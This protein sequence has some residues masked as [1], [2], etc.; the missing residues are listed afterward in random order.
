MLSSLDGTSGNI[1]NFQ[2]FG[3]N[4]VKPALANNGST[5]FLLASGTESSSGGESPAISLAGSYRYLYVTTSTGSGDDDFL[6]RS[7]TGGSVPVP[8]SSVPEPASL[9]LLAAG[10]IGLAGAGAAGEDASVYADTHASSLGYGSPRAFER[11]QAQR[12]SAA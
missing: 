5:V 4:L 2:I 11:Q 10:L 6:L 3:S 9:A 7:A 12:R 1:D 8:P